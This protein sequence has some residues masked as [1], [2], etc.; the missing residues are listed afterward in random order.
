MWSNLEVVFMIH[1]KKKKQITGLVVFV[2][3]EKEKRKKKTLEG[4]SSLWSMKRKKTK[5]KKLRRL[6]VLVINEKKK[7]KIKGAVLFVIN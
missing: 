6:V 1:E 4:R 2:I 5:K 7:K 3:N